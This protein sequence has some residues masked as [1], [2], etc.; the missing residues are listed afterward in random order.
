MAV[1][2]HN[3]VPSGTPVYSVSLSLKNFG[4]SPGVHTIGLMQYVY[5]VSGGWHWIGPILYPDCTR[6]ALDPGKSWTGDIMFKGSWD[7]CYKQT[8]FVGASGGLFVIRIIRDADWDDY[9]GEIAI[10]SS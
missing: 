3:A 10:P 1:F 6:I 7:L 8:F 9:I 2:D 4:T 5:S